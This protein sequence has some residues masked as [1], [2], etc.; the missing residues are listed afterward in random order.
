MHSPLSKIAVIILDSLL[1][2]YFFIFVF[3]KASPRSGKEESGDD[4]KEFSPSSD[5]DQNKVRL[6]FIIS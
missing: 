3:Q 5:S 1:M 2:C 6:N 4:S